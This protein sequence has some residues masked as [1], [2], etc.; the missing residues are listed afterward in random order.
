MGSSEPADADRT[1]ENKAVAVVEI[2]NVHGDRIK[3][4]VVLVVVE[5]ER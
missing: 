1:V 4:M 3:K 2:G 5:V